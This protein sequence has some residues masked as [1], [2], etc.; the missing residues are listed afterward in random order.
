MVPLAGRIQ[1][2][3]LLPAYSPELDNEN[4]DEDDC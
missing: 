2:G 3:S 4:D 1:N